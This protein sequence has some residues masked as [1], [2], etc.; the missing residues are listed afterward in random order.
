MRVNNRYTESLFYVTNIV[1]QFSPLFCRAPLHLAEWAA[2]YD[3]RAERNCVCVC[4]C[5]CIDSYPVPVCCSV[6]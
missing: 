4:V 3:K 6:E 2:F 1:C 5:V